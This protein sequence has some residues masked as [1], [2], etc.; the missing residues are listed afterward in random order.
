MTDESQTSSGPDSPP[1]GPADSEAAG[2]STAPDSS[3]VCASSTYAPYPEP[4]DAVNIH[5]SQTPCPS[6]SSRTQ[7]SAAITSTAS[8]PLSTPIN[9]SPAH[10]PLSVSP[11][12]SCSTLS[13]SLSPATTAT[14]SSL[15]HRRKG[16]ACKV[17]RSQRQRGRLICT[18]AARE[19]E[20]RSEEEEEREEAEGEE[21]MEEDVE[22]DEE[23]MEE[24]T[25][26]E[27]A[28]HQQ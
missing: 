19:G 2:C 1:R 5:P 28:G 8:N 27:T 10:C 18:P 7:P 13:S 25:S 20:R 14:L 9:S 11:A 15:G 26:G 17:R 6:S 22:Q 16:L 23:R 3:T 21:R 24:A 4:E 12:A